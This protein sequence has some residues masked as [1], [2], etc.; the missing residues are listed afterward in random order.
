MLIN[1]VT[2]AILLAIFIPAE[3]DCIH[4]F[5]VGGGDSR[6]CGQKWIRSEIA[7][8][9]RTFSPSSRRHDDVTTT[10]STYT[11]CV[12]D[13]VAFRRLDRDQVPASVASTLRF[14]PSKDV[15]MFVFDKETTKKLKT[16]VDTVSQ[17]EA[18]LHQ[19][20]GRPD[21]ENNPNAL[22]RSSDVPSVSARLRRR[23]KYRK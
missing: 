13:N 17:N 19:I 16:A 9:N 21:V 3:R 20:E 5:M 12:T 10:T 4:G 14:P 8:S 1:A 18:A 11:A 23:S 15:T 22:S 6:L 2:V 7:P